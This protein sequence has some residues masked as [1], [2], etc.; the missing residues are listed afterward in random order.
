MKILV[1][2]IGGTHVKVLAT[3]QDNHRDFASGPHLTPK[4]MVSGVRSLVTDWKY[5]AVS[6]GYPGPVRRNR[7]VAEPWNLGTGWAGFN[8]E[9]A[10]KCPVKLLNDAA[11]QAL[12]GYQ[13][14][15]MLFLG[16]GTGL[17]SAMIV[18]GIGA[19]GGS[20]GYSGAGA[21][22]PSMAFCL[23]TYGSNGTLQPQENGSTT[24]TCGFTTGGTC[25]FVFG[26]AID[27]GAE[28]TYNVVWNAAGKVLTLLVDGALVMTYDRDL[29]A[30]VF[31]G[32]TCVYYGFT[33]ATGGANNL[34]YIYQT[35]CFTDTPTPTPTYT[36]TMTPTYTA[37]ITATATPTNSITRTFTNTATNTATIT[38]TNT[39]T[40]SPTGTST[41]SPTASYT[42]TATQTATNT[43]TPTATKTSTYTATATRTDTETQ[44]ATNSPT[45]T[46]TLSPTASYTNTAT[47][48]ATD[49]ATKTQTFTLTNTPTLTKTFTLT[50]T[51]TFT[52]TLTPTLTPTYTATYTPTLTTTNTATFTITNTPPSTATPTLTPTFTPISVS[53]PVVYPNPVTGSIVTIQLPGDNLDN[54]EVQIFT[55]AFR[56]VQTIRVAQVV[57]KSL[58]V[59]LVDKSGAALANGLYYFVVH[60]GAQK[61]IMKVLVLK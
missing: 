44:T 53:S 56:K 3:G 8:Y 21:I 45:G 46:S 5:D 1:I 20:K 49:I 39:P 54:V 59:P 26:T 4:R 37:T 58:T 61:W 43:A 18:E 14:G 30:S 22:T 38:T 7:P 9:A 6:I 2:D 51:K 27:N 19:G 57:G 40:N 23:E 32:S 33:A 36:R 31:G 34:Q 52:S 60:V 48:T 29:V 25:P 24:S 41:L 55:L 16:L 11:M 42:K 35:N 12:G 47:Q 15:R 13:G 17:G 28:H 50:S 10:F